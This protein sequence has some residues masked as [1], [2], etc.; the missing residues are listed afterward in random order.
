MKNYN[1][2]I[3][4]FGKCWEKKDFSMLKDL[5]SANIEYYENPN[6]NP[7]TNKVEIVNQWEKDLKRQRE[8]SFSYEILKADE[9]LCI[10]NWKASFLI[11]TE[12][13]KYDGIYIIRLNENNQCTYFKQ[14]WVKL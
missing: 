5:L 3:T 9:N 8:I 6:Q 4:D 10:A 14:W 13:Y 2:W 1:S 11:D 12:E 7:L